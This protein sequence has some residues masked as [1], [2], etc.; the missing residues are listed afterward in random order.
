MRPTIRRDAAD[1]AA[2]LRALATRAHEA[3]RAAG[4]RAEGPMRHEL[5]ELRNAIAQLEDD[6]RSQNLDTVIPYV[7]ALR[8]QVEARLA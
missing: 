3:V 2:T 4:D 5:S 1:L 8:Q 7:V 6:F